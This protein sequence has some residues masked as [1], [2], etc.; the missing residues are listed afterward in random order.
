[1]T[2]VERLREVK[3]KKKTNLTNR[4]CQCKMQNIS[5]KGVFYVYFYVKGVFFCCD[6]RI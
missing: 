6:K 4:N 2:L 3:K 5:D 1:M